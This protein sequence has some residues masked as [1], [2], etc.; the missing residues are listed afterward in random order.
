MIAGLDQRFGWT[1]TIHP[2]LQAAGFLV[3]IAATAFANWATRVNRFFSSAVRIQADRGHTVVTTGPYEIIR[4]P[5]Y[6][7]FM[8]LM[9]AG[10]IALG[11]L[12]SLVPALVWS[13][14]FIRRAAI[15]DRMLRSNLDG[16]EDYARRVRFRLIPRVW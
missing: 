15:E 16:Y 3:M 4:H 1:G 11:S 14:L 7:G 12:W 6:A 5:G 8:I 10:S 9:I 2:V 13:V